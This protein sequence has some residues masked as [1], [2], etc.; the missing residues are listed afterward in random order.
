MMPTAMIMIY[1]YYTKPR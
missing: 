1:K